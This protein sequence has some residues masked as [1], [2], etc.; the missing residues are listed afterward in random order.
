[1]KP[2]GDGPTFR[3]PTCVVVDDNRDAADS[4]ALLLESWGCQASAAYDGRSG[5]E[6]A[7][8]LKPDAVLLDLRMPGANGFEVCRSIRR[9]SWSAETVIL[10]ITGSD[11][12]KEDALTDAG[13]DGVFGKPIE[14]EP[15]KELLDL[16]RL[17]RAAASTVTPSAPRSTPKTPTSHSRAG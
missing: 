16:I 11:E 1:M 7:D 10:A 6:L 12:D 15:L 14:L 5:V 17:R 13:F 4:L 3:R 2:D 8:A 9:L